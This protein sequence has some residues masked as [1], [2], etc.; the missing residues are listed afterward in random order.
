M[1]VDYLVARHGL[2]PRSGLAYDYIVAGDGVFVSATNSLLDVRIPVA[3]RKIRGLDPVFA[4]CTLLHG[5]V[6]AGLWGAVLRCLHF[7]RN[8]GCEVLV[9]IDIDSANRYRVVVPE[10][11]VGPLAVEYAPKEG[12]VLEVHSHLDGPAYFSST[13][14]AD[15]QGLRLYGV[16]VRLGQPRPRVALRAG[17]Y[18]YF[19]PIPWSSVFDGDPASIDDVY[20]DGAIPTN[21]RSAMLEQNKW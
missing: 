6:P 9:G 13:D 19:L 3:R 1:L 4:A 7:A 12:W 2:P 14:T 15:E 20:A 5:R 11:R 18:G 17:A 21:E 10:Q 8:S 16:V